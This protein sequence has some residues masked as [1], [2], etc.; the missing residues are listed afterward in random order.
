MEAPD[1]PGRDLALLGDVSNRP[2]AD[3][4]G[5]GTAGQGPFTIVAMLL[6]LAG[7]R[8]RRAGSVTEAVGER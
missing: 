5:C 3:L 2:D 7:A 8:R 1:A 4:K 6:A